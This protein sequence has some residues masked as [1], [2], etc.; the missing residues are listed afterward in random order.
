MSDDVVSN[1]ACKNCVFFVVKDDLPFGS[2]MVA[3]GFGECRRNAPSGL[4]FVMIVSKGRHQTVMANAFPPV[5]ERD[6]CGRFQLP[7]ERNAP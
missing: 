7:H 3:E 6:W 5:H 1:R 2:E 4:S